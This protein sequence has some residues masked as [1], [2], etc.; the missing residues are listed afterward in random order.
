[1]IRLG[2]R[3]DTATIQLRYRYDTTTIPLR[4]HYDT[5]TTLLRSA[6]TPLRYYYNTAK[7]TA[8]FRYGYDI[9]ATMLR[10]H[11]DTP[12]IWLRYVSS[13]DSNID[14]LHS[15]LKPDQAQPYR[16]LTMNLLFFLTTQITS[17]GCQYYVITK[18]STKRKKYCCMNAVHP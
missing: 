13:D 2:Y 9:A 12:M 10:Y 15:Y 11:Y 18:S 14:F 17:L 8:P 7:T 6:T 5:A 16:F 3:Y 4:Y 1:M